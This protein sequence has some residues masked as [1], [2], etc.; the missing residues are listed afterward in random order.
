MPVVN[1]QWLSDLILG[2]M[3]ALRMPI[4]TQYLQI[5]KGDQFQMDLGKVQLLMGK[6]F[7]LTSLVN[8]TYMPKFA[9]L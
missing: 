5:S 1:V 2:Y 7:Y 6:A 9:Y 4:D 3:D 8:G